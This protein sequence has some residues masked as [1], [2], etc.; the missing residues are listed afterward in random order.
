MCKGSKKYNEA[1]KEN[2]LERQ[3]NFR[4]KKEKKE[5]KLKEILKKE[6]EDEIKKNN[7]LL[8][9]SEEN[10]EN[11]EKNKVDVNK[12]IK[13]LYDWEAQRKLKIKE[14]KDK[15]DKTVETTYDYVPKI[16]EKSTM[17]AEKNELK[18]KEPNVFLRLA[19]HDQILK[20][21]KRILIQMYTPTFQPQS[22][23]PRNMKLENLKKK[24]YMSKRENQI[25][26]EEDDEE[27][28]NYKRSRRRTKTKR[29]EDSD[30]ENEEDENEEDED[31]EDEEEEEEEQ[32]QQEE[33]DFD[34]QQ[35]T[36]KYAE[37]DVQDALRN[38]LFH[39]KKKTKK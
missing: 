12:R 19:S 13:G 14:K 26:E 34:Y 25:E 27:E 18:I 38:A 15:E 32:E 8:Q 21:K 29:N 7:I 39:K 9:K 24:N 17:L 36:M 37:D 2:F 35:D 30:E 4:E 22:Y 31:E 28:E 16:N 33:D 11:S 20:E 6:K 3:K 10:K 23:V 1:K 5:E